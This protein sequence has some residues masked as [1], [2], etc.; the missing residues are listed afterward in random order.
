[1]AS[2]GYYNCN[3]HHYHMLSLLSLIVVQVF[4]TRHCY[5]TYM[6][7][8]PQDQKE[9]TFNINPGDY[10]PNVMTP[11]L[12]S[13]RCGAYDQAFSA[14]A[15]GRFCFC[16]DTTP[17]M[18]DK[19]PNSFCQE[20]CSGDAT[21]KCGGLGYVSL[22]KSSKPITGLAIISDVTGVIAVNNLVTFSVSIT[23][24]V[25]VYY[26]MDYDDGGGLSDKNATDFDSHS[27]NLPGTYTVRIQANDFND[28]LATQ[29][30]VT[31]VVVQA[32][33]SGVDL[34]CD[35]VFAT[36][37]EGQCL[38][39]VWEGTALSLTAQFAASPSPLPSPTTFAIADPVISQVG[40]GIPAKDSI[41]LQS[42][43]LTGTVVAQGSLVENP[44]R[45]VGWEL[46]A[47]TT[48]TFKVL[49]LSPSCSGTVYC[50][51]SNQCEASCAGAAEVYAVQCG[52][53]TF[54]P[55]TRLCDDG[56]CTPSARFSA[57]APLIATYT[58]KAIVDV[59]VMT[60]GYQYV[61][62][63][64]LVEVAAGDILG[65]DLAASA[66]ARPYW[67][68]CPSDRPDFQ[69]NAGVVL[70]DFITTGS[71]TVV[72]E[73]MAVRAAVSE[74]A[75]VYLPYTFTEEGD[76]PLTVT[77]SNTGGIA[78]TPAANTTT[79]HVLEGVNFTIIDGPTYVA[80]GDPA[81]FV[82][83]PHTGAGALYTWDQVGDGVTVLVNT[84]DQSKAFTYGTKGTY[85]LTVTV[86]NAVSSKTNQTEV[87][88]QD[89]VTGLDVAQATAP[90]AEPYSFQ[91]TLTGGSDYTCTWTF[92]DGQTATS[93]ETTTPAT[94]SP[95]AFTH[96]YAT[97]GD[98][99]FE[100]TCANEVSSMTKAFTQKVQERIVG[101]AL[102]QQGQDTE[103]SL[104]VP[105]KVAT[106]SDI[107]WSVTLNGAPIN[108]DTAASNPNGHSW[109]SQAMGLMSSGVYTVG[110]SGTN[111]LGTESITES[112]ELTTAI[113]DFDALSSTYNTTTG[114]EVEFTV[115]MS[116]GSDVNVTVVY[117]D[118]TVFTTVYSDW[119]GTQVYK[120]VY[121][122]GGR[123]PVAVTAWN[124][125]GAFSKTLEVLILAGVYGIMMRSPDFA[126]YSPPSYIDVWFELPANMSEPTE[127][128]LLLDFDYKDDPLDVEL[129]LNK[130]YTTQY[131]D[132]GVFNIAA[133]VSNIL[134]AKSF[135]RPLVIIDIL[136]GARIEP[137]FPKAPKGQDLDVK[138]I[139]YRGPK[140]PYC[141][142]TW[143]AGDPAVLTAVTYRQGEGMDGYDIQPINYPNL[144]TYTLT[145]TATTPLQTLSKSM[146]M[147][148]VEPILLSSLTVT[149]DS[150]T[151][152]WDFTA[153]VTVTIEWTSSDIPYSPLVSILWG[154]GQ[155]TT[156]VPFSIA[157]P[158]SQRIF[159]HAF[160]VDGLMTTTVTV[161]NAA[162][163][164]DVPLTMGL[165]KNFQ[166]MK[167]NKC[168]W[169]D[170][171]VGTPCVDGLTGHPNK[172]SSDKPVQ[173][174]ILTDQN[175]KA[176][177]YAIEATSGANVIVCNKTEN[178]FTL[179]LLQSGT[180]TVKIHAFN[181]LYNQQIS[182]TLTIVQKVVGFVITHD[183][184]QKDAGVPKVFTIA[185]TNRGTDTCLS[186]DFGDSTIYYYADNAP[187]CSGNPIR[188]DLASLT[189]IS[190]TYMLQ[191]TF[192][193]T[194]K[195]ENAFNS[196]TQT[197]HL[198]I[199]GMD[200]SQPQV[201]IDKAAVS[202]K[203]PNSHYKGAFITIRAIPKIACEIYQNVKS[204]VVETVDTQWGTES[205]VVTLPTSVDTATA[206]LTMEPWTLDY[207]LYKITFTMSMSTG[208]SNLQFEATAYTYINVV[209]SALVGLMVDGGSSEI[210]WGTSGGNLVL[211]PL[212]FSYDPDVVNNDPATSGMSIVNWTCTHKN[213]SAA[214][215]CAGLVSAAT[216]GSG[217]R[218]NYDVNLLVVGEAYRISVWMDKAER[219]V[220]ASVDVVIVSGDPAKVVIK[221]TGGSICHQ[222]P[223]GFL[224]LSSSQ[225]SLSAECENCVDGDY[226]A[227]NW[228]LYIYDYRWKP[229]RPLRD[230]DL[231]Q[232]RTVGNSS[233][234][235]LLFPAFFEAFSE[236]TLYKAECIVHRN[237]VKSWAATEI[238]LN[239]PPVPGTC[240]V[241]PKEM[242]VT[243]EKLVR[244]QCQG[245]TDNDTGIA[246]FRFISFF[247]VQ[248][249]TSEITTVKTSEGKV[250]VNV[251][252][253]QGAHWLDNN[254]TVRVHVI[255]IMGARTE[256]DI[257]TVKVNPVPVSEARALTQ[258]LLHS[259]N[260]EMTRL[261]AEGD[262]VTCTEYATTIATVLNSDKFQ[263]M[264]I[265]STQ[266]ATGLGPADGNR[267]GGYSEQ[268]VE[269]TPEEE[270]QI[271]HQR[272]DRAELRSKVINELQ[273]LPDNTFQGRAQ[274]M[275]TISEVMKYPDEVTGETQM[276]VVDML[277][278]FAD[279]L[280][281]MEPV[282]PEERQKMMGYMISCLGGVMTASVTTMFDGTLTE[283]KK[284]QKD[285]R[286][287]DYPTDSRAVV[288]KC[289]RDTDEGNS[290]DKAL[291]Y[292]RRETN[293]KIQRAIA[294]EMEEKSKKV[295]T[296]IATSFGKN[297]I[298]GETVQIDTDR[299]R[300][301]MAK[302]TAKNAFSAEN[303][304]LDFS[305]SG[306]SFPNFND[307]F[308]AGMDENATFVVQVIEGSENPH[309]YTDK[310][311]DIP[312]TSRFVSIDIKEEDDATGGAGGAVAV[313]NTAKPIYI[314]IANAPDAPPARNSTVDPTLTSWTR[315]ML[316]K[317]SIEKPGSSFHFTICPDRND[318]Q[319]VA[320]VSLGAVPDPGAGLCNK[321]FLVPVNLTDP[322]ADGCTTHYLDNYEMDNYV[323]EAYVGVRQLSESEK[324]LDVTN[325]TELPRWIKGAEN[326]TEFTGGYRITL[327]STACYVLSDGDEDWSTDSCRVYGTTSFESTV[328][329]CNH[330]TTFAGGWVVVPNTIDWDYVFS[331][332][333]FFKNPTLYITEM[334][335]AFVYIVS[336][337]WARRK[338]KKDVEKLGIAPLVDNDPKDKYY[339]E[340]VVVTGMRKNAGTDSKVFFILSGEEDET[341]VREFSD[342]KRKIF[343]R[344]ETNGFLMAH[345][346]PLGYLNY[347]RVWH[348]NSGKANMGGWYMNYMIVRDVQ[349]DEKWVFIA[350]K[351]FAVEEDD[352]QVDRIIPVAT[353]ENMTE[354]SHMFA[355]RTRKNLADGH[356]WFSVV[357]R[358]PASRFTCLQRVSCCLC[359]L[360][361]SMLA[362]AMFYKTAKEDSG[363]GFTLGPFSIAPEQI[364][365]GIA[366][367]IIVFPVN[368]IIITLFRKARP[369]KLRPSRV[370]EAIKTA[371]DGPRTEASVTDIKPE[372]SSI[373]S[374][375]RPSS[376]M[377]NPK[378]PRPESSLS[379]PGTSLSA[380]ADA[381]LPTKKKKS[382]SLP[383]WC[384]II[385]W[386]LL[387]VS[388][389][390]AA[391]FVTFYGV[392]FAD[393]TCKKW[394]SSMLV[395]FFMSVFITQPIKV[396][397]IAIFLS[398]IIKNP[399]ESE[400]D[401]EEQD[402]EKTK[403]ANDEIPL[404]DLS[405]DGF[406]AAK[407]RKIGY[408]PPDRSELEAARQKRLNEIQMWSIVREVV[409]YSFFLWILLVISYRQR[410]SDTF[411]YKDTMERV[412]I[413]NNETDIDFGK[414][415]NVDE[416]WY[417][418]K[419]G[420]VNG[421]RAGPYYNDYPPL[422]LRGYVNDKVSKILG[423]A[424]MRQLR[425]QPNLCEMDERMM[426]VIRECNIGYDITDQEEGAFD[427]GWKP[428]TENSTV[429]DTAEWYSYTDS[430]T[431]N[432]YPYWGM[433]S[434][435]SGGGYVVPLKG[436][437]T[438][439]IE[440][441][442]RLEQE[443]W[444]DRYTRAVFVEFTTYNAQV[445]L[446][447][448]ATILAEFHQ[449]GGVVQSYRFEPA[450]L[451]P[452]MTSAM[453]FQLVCEGVYCCFIIFFIVRL[454]RTFIKEKLAFFKGFWNLVEMGIIAMS[455]GAIVIYFYRLFETNK[456][457]SRFKETNGLDYIKFQYVGYWNEIFTYMIGWT[458]FFATLKFMRLLRFNKRMSLLASTLRNGA[459]SLLHFS[460]IFW[461]VFL[462]FSMLFFLSYMTIDIKYSSFIG[463]VVSGILM[464][465][466]KF[467][468]YTLTMAEPILTQIFVFLF[469]V[470]VTF[471]IVNMFVSILNETFSAVRD[472]VSKQS[473]DYEIISFMISRFKRFT[474]M[475]PPANTTLTPEEM[476][477]QELEQRYAEG[478]GN[479]CVD[480][481]P[482]RIDRLLHSISNV[483][484]EQEQMSAMMDKRGY[485][486]GLG[487]K[488]YDNPGYVGPRGKATG[489]SKVDTH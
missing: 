464:M 375:S 305:S 150:A 351:W 45:V 115:S 169:P 26:Q 458:V 341:D 224:V 262:L 486:H 266:T 66:G 203:N 254:N 244:I 185:F 25:D 227:Y 225:L 463:S 338:D 125:A 277:E 21:S 408:K 488:G 7:C 67:L 392:S 470:S 77:V 306:L 462:A 58:V 17:S 113:A 348:D 28:T 416:Y 167:A 182:T 124:A 19:V 164:V 457:T 70:G 421:I 103:A 145:V 445:N 11:H 466:G 337:I 62:E 477:N 393:E 276:V 72:G 343:R 417:W 165:Y 128:K 136:E 116:K 4:F 205:G 208:D 5:A 13:A 246:E 433:L 148:V 255:D 377:A 275:S 369:R 284:S 214:G 281:T 131:D 20:L 189:S 135:L 60:T 151:N 349:T 326:A 397:L 442:K 300:V 32:P 413:M 404:H 311:R 201:D 221:C 243:T 101:L 174:D 153:T 27:Y 430:D 90:A 314:T 309:R 371:H 472:D 173:F 110:V 294:M 56:T 357:A 302:T 447:G 376:M 451:L 202:F 471:I 446:F 346:R 98:K 368:F 261:F 64:G 299:M 401:E 143:D 178:P 273:K 452:Y 68:D 272:D 229:W 232:N 437:R 161:H 134:D 74:G 163:S 122:N 1:M 473:N 258:E 129:E 228:T 35:P 157:G 467:D 65:V 319:Y 322:P 271:D 75:Q 16:G 206:E 166:G 137:A 422:M 141:N 170:L 10:D 209:K 286:F 177:Y 407:P 152:Q 389:A 187:D 112:Y 360:Y 94:G 149:P 308:P 438:T 108:V 310:G 238:R 239:N 285:E 114:T 119:P 312:T 410:N 159:T 339:Y 336:A 332:M 487:A 425:V 293:C 328:C 461:I 207:G 298:Q 297:S 479:S 459:R 23:K 93:D 216:T 318:V 29:E 396:F 14:L 335:I 104:Q 36:Y 82:V 83:E 249:V 236:Y 198:E 37:D 106:G 39:T 270:L 85:N 140:D 97:K 267:V 46:N 426:A 33:V 363:N 88:V 111:D 171:P 435:Y 429:N 356:L 456:L 235:I 256:M 329:E 194:A 42:P 468:I 317:T 175:T 353:R 127:P 96:T 230:S 313:A 455:L 427:I 260:N 179:E 482:E 52:A 325:C 268:T 76:F 465:M 402:E 253:A 155:E 475:G 418:A 245:W 316:H 323:G 434:V 454:I 247:D 347:A 440:L 38:V 183:S 55:R 334:V 301:K 474:G 40:P 49:I 358:P 200:C 154:D 469:V 195:A 380:R 248:T 78:A 87:I 403:L 47:E 54:C 362:N 146:T 180:W 441:M 57:T 279:Q 484:M 304:G 168:F 412:F 222:L 265:P 252:L 354:F 359:L 379:R 439:L 372:V 99:A 234:Q 211:E 391:A 307:I 355:E 342:S 432:G 172:F 186:V 63:S 15:Y 282:P 196:I 138:F 48:G 340:I 220:E 73:C 9:R 320:V 345:T 331:N 184:A 295:L 120:H 158:N 388:V 219:A 291:K 233:K 144:G 448:I 399:G 386:I 394:I 30:A 333:D 190:H 92:G 378:P 100:V 22:Y 191:K 390:V 278:R 43:G 373:F 289:L 192:T 274:I 3:Y 181:P 81:T 142:L 367:N 365:I 280:D 59:T 409:I 489:L 231:G 71:L 384:S 263:G 242:T 296:Q 95:V 283:Q 315:F 176:T 139:L 251:T 382:K 2:Y 18:S 352:G 102:A 444:I 414:I 406:G 436:D 478:R 395:S 215:P 428:R 287:M 69:Q 431:L 160:T 485:Q 199:T 6:G 61:A 370:D 419:S 361:V 41:A 217:G 330:L 86:A 53:Q 109:V 107:I 212:S 193:V 226:I 51:L 8:F 290:F 324:G 12:C 105:W 460:I 240:V 411:L 383:W 423:Y 197:L 415:R 162:S 223:Q 480:D 385:A 420:M 84:T 188:G 210:V 204:W 483:Y 481:F 303:L 288:K 50:P 121:T 132:R 24:G 350:D 450:M 147:E 264:A 257:D 250:D 381:T 34:D 126:L 443:K 327:F 405:A 398:L 259:D 31:T 117:Q 89:K 237:G 292:Q 366:S 130:N 453:L 79:A 118:D 123:F 321:S 44:G 241:A 344:G 374:V 156:D 218:L 80:T 449:T 387:W 213:G 364:F 476:R 269:I 400:E 133:T 91:I 424:V